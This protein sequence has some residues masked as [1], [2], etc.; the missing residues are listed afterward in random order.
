MGSILEYSFELRYDVHRVSIPRWEIQQPY[1]IHK[2]H[3]AFT[4]L[5]AFLDGRGVVG[6]WTVL[7]EHGNIADTLLWW[8]ILPAG[9]AVKQDNTGRLMVDVNDVPP[10]P[11]EEWMP[12]V[13]NFRYRVNFYYLKDPHVSSFWNDEFKYWS[14]YVDRFAEPS[15]S[16]K[17]AVAGL[18]CA[19][20]HSDLDKACKLY[21]AVQ[22]LDNTDF[23]RKKSDAELRELKQKVAKHAEDTWA[24][25]S[26]SGEDIALLYLAMLRA[27]GLSANA[28]KVVDRE[29]GIFDRSYLN[30]HQ[31]DTTIVILNIAGK[32]I[33][34]DP[35]E[36][37]CPFQTVSWRHSER[38]RLLAG[39]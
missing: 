5:S 18:I 32:E 15:K 34:L 28:M 1:F 11:D 36:K 39:Q 26:G 4:P 24:Q 35:G 16:I 22:G 13:Q 38:Q 29:K 37:M 19:R 23:S 6:D 30:A 33:T 21:T 7:D 17:E 12:P 10:M 25:K 9:V 14:K 31:F 3:F 8:P 27:A 2:A 20:R